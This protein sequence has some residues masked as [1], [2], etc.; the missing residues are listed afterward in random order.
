MTASV[1]YFPTRVDDDDVEAVAQALA[2]EDHL[3]WA[4]VREQPISLFDGVCKRHYREKAARI[5]NVL[6]TSR[7]ERRGA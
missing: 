1:T 7:R 5:L 4:L 2:G 3:P 6:S